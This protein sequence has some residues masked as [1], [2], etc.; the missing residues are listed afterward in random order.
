MDQII[1][2]IFAIIRQSLTT[3]CDILTSPAMI[4]GIQSIGAT[5]AGFPPWV[6]VVIAIIVIRRV[7]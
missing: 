6:L 2:T 3:F 7:F 1:N 5:A 4:S